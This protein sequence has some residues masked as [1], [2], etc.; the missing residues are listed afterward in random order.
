M[1]WYICDETKKMYNKLCVKFF[2]NWFFVYVQ[3]K[4]AASRFTQS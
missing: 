1:Y 4:F 3:E 2:C